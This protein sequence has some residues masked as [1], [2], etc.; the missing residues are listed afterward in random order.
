M[1]VNRPRLHLLFVLTLVFAAA[2]PDPVLAQ[3][4][5]PTVNLGDTNFEDAFAGP[6]WFFEE[7]PDVYSADAIKGSDGKALPGSNR[8]TAYST[9]THI[10][11]VGKKHLLG[12]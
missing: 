2:A 1:T 6:G 9:T 10:A 8:F 5:L 12:G 4:Q 7:F 3:V 11:F